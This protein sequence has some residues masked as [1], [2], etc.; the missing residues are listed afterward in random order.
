M[1]RDEIDAEYTSSIEKWAAAAVEIYYLTDN[2]E[3]ALQFDSREFAA[4]DEGLLYIGP[5]LL[6]FFAQAARRY[7]HIAP[8]EDFSAVVRTGF[9]DYLDGVL[10]LFRVAGQKEHAYTVL[11]VFGQLYLQPGAFVPE[12]AVGYLEKDSRSVAGIVVGFG[13]PVNKLFQLWSAR[14]L[15][16]GVRVR[17]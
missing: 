13:P 11:T 7:G 14:P 15:L 9:L 8:S 2:I 1:V 16:S 6:G 3:S 5:G 10:V 17:P 4:A 12:K